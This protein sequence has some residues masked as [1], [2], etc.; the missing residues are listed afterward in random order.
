MRMTR[1]IGAVAAAIALI[2]AAGCS[3]S[4]DDKKTE[5]GAAPGGRLEKVTYLTGAGILGRESYVYVAM[6]KGFFK[7]AGFDVQVQAGKGT[8]PNI[9]LLQAG[10]VDFAVLDIT[11]AL[12]AY[13]RGTYKDFTIVSAIQQR[14]LACFMAFSGSGIS[15]P[16]DLEGKKIAFIPGGIVK[17]LFDTYAKLAGVDPTK[18]TWVATQPEALV[19]A[20][21][22]GSV[23][24]ATQ[25]VVGK[26]QVEKVAKEK[27]QSAVVLPFSDQLTDLYGNGLGV[28]RKLATE[29]PD[30]VKR[31]NAAML[32]GLQ[33]ALDNPDEAGKIYAKYQ[34][35]QPEPVAAAEMKLMISYAKTS[36]T[37]LGSLDEQKATQNVAALQSGGAIPGQINPKDVINFDIVAKS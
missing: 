22:S 7:E 25:F 27:G 33:Y 34:K 31:F 16:K 15:T 12:I 37:A 2:L 23:D 20:M 13:G 21:S 29:N 11:A 5:A 10:A 32:K 30:K 4:D 6:D 8:D 36:G 28:S 35:T 18:V 9:K 19:P 26:P 14:N 1:L 3:G 24:A 17:T